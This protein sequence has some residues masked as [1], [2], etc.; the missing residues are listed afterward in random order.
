M[1]ERR[2][3]IFSDHY[4]LKYITTQKELNLRQRK[5]MELIKDYDC[6]IKYHP[7]K[8]NI[9]ADA[10][11]YKPT[12]NLASIRA[13]QIPLMLELRGLNAGLEVDTLEAL[14]ASFSARPLLLGEIYEVQLQDP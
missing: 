5:W 3:Q 6:T 12:A 4:S 8:A 9:V 10:L 13:V 1:Y 11:S 2:Y 14:L 7:D